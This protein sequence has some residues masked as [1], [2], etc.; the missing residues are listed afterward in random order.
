MAV[1]GGETEAPT[2]FLELTCPRYNSLE[3]FCEISW[4]EVFGSVRAQTG[5]K[6][7]FFGSYQISLHRTF[8]L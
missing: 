4:L 5:S 2:H 6:K 7:W 1:A 8:Q 3:P